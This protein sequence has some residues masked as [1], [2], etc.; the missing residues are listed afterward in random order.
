MTLFLGTYSSLE[1]ISTT[2]TNSIMADRFSGT[3]DV[4]R[5]PLKI[6]HHQIVIYEL[7]SIS[8]RSFSARNLIVPTRG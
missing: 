6:V 4:P 3:E 5:T 7:L 8:M 2:V 1:D